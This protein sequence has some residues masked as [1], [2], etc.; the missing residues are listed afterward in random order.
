[1]SMASPEPPKIP[2]VTEAVKNPSGA[3]SALRYTGIPPS[4][5][6][7]RPKL[8][9]RNWLIF[10]SLIGSV[11]SLYIYDRRTAKRIRQEYVEKVQWRAEERLDPMEFPRKVRV[12]G[13]RWPGDDDHDRSMKYFRR[14]VKPIL[15]AAAIDFEMINGNRHGGLARS[16]ADK[17]KLQRR[18]ALPQDHPLHYD[19][20]V[21]SVPLPTNQTPAKQ[22]QRELEGGIIIVGRHTLKE[23]THGLRLG[24]SESLS[25]PD[26]EEV[27][28]RALAADG[29]FDEPNLP[30]EPSEMADEP[31]TASASN[32]TTPAGKSPLFSTIIAPPRTSTP[33]NS[34]HRPSPPR[35]VMPD[36][37]PRE[38]PPQ[39]PVLLL[40]FENL[41]GFRYVPHIIVDF[42]NERKRVKAGAEA[43]YTLI[44]AQ[45]RD[46]L[47]P[48][49]EVEGKELPDI[50]SFGRGKEED[51]KSLPTVG[52]QGGDVDF[53][54]YVEGY[55]R[56][57]Y[58]D[59]PKDTAK[60]RKR[61]YDDLPGKLAA[62][63]S[64]ARNEREPTKE[65][66]NFPPPT[67]V[68]LTTERFK[69]ELKWYENLEGW[70]LLRA[71]S[72]VDWDSR[73]ATALRVYVPPSSTGFD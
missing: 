46:F 54:H 71:G 69:K 70:K 22:R 59:V 47:P 8:P 52:P 53:D 21:S 20:P 6:Q 32:S 62:A 45:T 3:L 38:I 72:G 35:P 61:Y 19:N 12:Y 48:D 37:P 65:E 10:W 18:E 26:R 9:S 14:Y 63:R 24:W 51:L 56:K 40:P 44:E 11:T 2:T 60:A 50:L 25:A 66:R 73:L 30:G 42:F 23:Y 17:I 57:N 7:K 4:W 49:S 67:E 36:I 64:L 68:E 55:Y 1:M 41:L 43:A 58:N 31:S 39:P 27:L 29:A 33:Q 16:I 13:C 15:V 5:F 34:S 28:A